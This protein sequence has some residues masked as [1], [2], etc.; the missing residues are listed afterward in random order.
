MP[1]QIVNT[2]SALGPYSSA[3][4]AGNQLYVAGTGGFV[5]GT[6]RLVE[7]GIEAEIR[8]TLKNLEA[9]ITQAGFALH[10]VVSTTCYL[11]DM[12]DWPLLNEVYSDYFTENPPARAAVAVSDM[13]ADTNV[14]ITCVAWR[15]EAN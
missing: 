7:G 14:E 3:V 9:T 13:P 4:I 5:P 8:Q 12:G 2:G 10:D 1:K 11:R 6:A 15:D